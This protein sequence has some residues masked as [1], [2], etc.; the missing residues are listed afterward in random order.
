MEK[1]FLRLGNLIFRISEIN[2]VSL[3]IEDVFIQSDEAHRNYTI[4]INKHTKISY[5]KETDAISDYEKVSKLLTGEEKLG[6]YVSTS[7][8]YNSDSRVV[9]NMA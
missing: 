6:D 4:T 7:I 5:L 1:V 3:N 2:S 9:A 8:D